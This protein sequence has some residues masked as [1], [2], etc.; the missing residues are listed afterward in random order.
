ML[1]L[2]SGLENQVRAVKLEGV[3]GIVQGAIITQIATSPDL[4][5]VMLAGVSWHG[6][7]GTAPM[8]SL[9]G[10][11]H[12]KSPSA[13]PWKN[14]YEPRTVAVTHGATPGEVR[15]L[16]A[17]DG[18]QETNNGIFRLYDRQ[19]HWTKS[20]IPACPTSYTREYYSQIKVSPADP[21]H[22]YIIRYCDDLPQD[23]H[24]GTMI[25]N[26]LYEGYASRDGGLRFQ[27]VY[28]K[29][30]HLDPPVQNLG[31]IPD[32]PGSLTPSPVEPDQV[33]LGTT[34][35]SSD[36]GEHWA[37][38]SF[39]V[40][41]LE[42]DGVDADQLY[43]FR[44][45]RDKPDV[46]MTR[47]RPVTGWRAWDNQ[48]CENIEQLVAHPTRK[49][50]LF[51]RC[52]NSR[53]KY[54]PDTGLFLSVDSGDHWKKIADWSGNWIGPDYSESAGWRVL[55][56]RDDGLW[57]TSGLGEDWV[58]LTANYAAQPEAEVWE[59]ATPPEALRDSKLAV[60]SA[61]D[62]WAGDTM[63][64]LMH[65]DGRTWT[66]VS[67]P[68][69]VHLKIYDLAFTASDNGWMVAGTSFNRPDH[70][71]GLA[72]HWDGHAW[73]QMGAGFND[74]LLGIT[75]IGEQAWAVGEN[76]LI[77]HWDGT[78]WTEMDNPV[79]QPNAPA[80]GMQLV[81]ISMI[82]PEEGW[83]VGGN[84]FGNTQGVIMHYRQDVWKL[85]YDTGE[86]PAMIGS[87]TMVSPTLG[88]ATGMRDQ[89]WTPV[90]ALSPNQAWAAYGGLES[91][92]SPRGML[93]RW[94]GKTWQQEKRASIFGKVTAA[95][96]WD[97]WVSGENLLHWDGTSWKSVELP[98]VRIED[99]AMLPGGDLWLT[100][101]T[102]AV[103]NLNFILH[104]GPMP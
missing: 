55:W 34:M 82:S 104:H 46:G 70:H 41:M 36:G 92:T 59:N 40:T 33:Y 32:L 101:E 29:A 23:M 49:G 60:L 12:W 17:G 83:A 79:R 18:Y 57:A 54:P 44:R 77:V 48:P 63:G 88:W 27:R 64:D 65:W 28:Q 53:E 51:L 37:T 3:A 90:G 15:L 97:A 68:T 100:A 69:T 78:E 35:I 31:Q 98:G 61:D 94:D 16:V 52:N 43:G 86:V 38:T 66:R 42:P 22:V 21:Q 24:D 91:A 10:G 102:E 45:E 58:R 76:N 1:A 9:D 85:E 75:A 30:I 73:K 14:H 71:L 81:E 26:L 95:S 84:V 4:P 72:Y 56:A 62:I 2:M 5:G 87:V 13:L 6:D 96:Q 39:P 25:Y 67:Y 20:S 7:E 93:L 47:L 99:M 8:Y 19:G 80:P 89:P 103:G 74:Q 50:V 11:K